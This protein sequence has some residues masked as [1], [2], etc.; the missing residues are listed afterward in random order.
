MNNKYQ[1]K[2][3]PICTNNLV[4]LND[5]SVC[6]YCYSKE[7]Y[8]FNNMNI[9][10]I[11][12]IVGALLNILAIAS[13]DGKMP[14]LADQS[15]NLSNLGSHFVFQDYTEVN[16]YYI[17]DIFKMGG[18]YFSIGDVI[19]FISGIILSPLFFIN[20]YQIIQRRR[21]LKHIKQIKRGLK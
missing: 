18:I 11:V 19:M 14:V 7:K 4:I 17:T 5:I 10:V 3:C 16:K 12:M 9:W 15:V 20:I 1:L 13:N 6:G 8:P 21:F 2:N